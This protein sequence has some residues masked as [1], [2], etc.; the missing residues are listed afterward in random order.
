MAAVENNHVDRARELVHCPDYPIWATG[1]QMA[2]PMVRQLVRSCA[3]LAQ[4][5]TAPP[6]RRAP[7][8]PDA[9]PRE[10]R[11]TWPPATPRWSC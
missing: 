7:P 3:C 8:R 10:T 11:S 1:F 9:A 4:S 6:L 5:R 2:H